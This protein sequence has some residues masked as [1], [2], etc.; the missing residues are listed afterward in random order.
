MRLGKQFEFGDK[1]AE[2]TNMVGYL[3]SQY[4]DPFYP[5]VKATD[6][7]FVTLKGGEKLVN[8]ASCDYLGFSKEE[9]LQDVAIEAIRTHGLNITGAQIF[10]GY[11]EIHRDLEQK[12]ARLYNKEGACLFASGML[13]N[14]GVLTSLVGPN[15]VIF[16]DIYNHASLIAGSKLS[17]AKNCLFPHNKLDR[18]DRE[19]AKISDGTKKLIAVDGVYSADG[20]AAP[21]TDLAAIAMKHDA[22]LVV[23]EAHALGVI[24]RNLG[25]A[26]DA[27]S[28]LD[29]VTVITGTMSKA[30]G[31]VGGFVAGPAE[32]IDFLK[33]Q[34]PFATSSRG[35]PYGLAA[36]SSAALDL[37]PSL[38][39]ERA[40]KTI[41]S[42]NYFAD[43]NRTNG[44]QVL[45]GPSA[46]VSIIFGEAPATI[47]MA[48]RLRTRGIL[49]S[50]MLHPSVPKRL[51]RLRF[52]VTCFH[53]DQDIEG[54]ADIIR[55]E[56]S[57]T[58]QLAANG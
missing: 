52:C 19:L 26:A 22:Y 31:S 33:H 35:T 1:I 37:L 40:E 57:S 20:D 46:I 4:Q 56:M 25:G 45:S 10:S 44:L 48:M 12:I 47:D 21:I 38:G 55:E 15:D 6:R 18:L 27:T 43:L 2:F 32:L 30:L 54:A 50:P 39:R 3:R 7:Q 53:E 11:S 13:A 14:I 36:A 41:R 49:A 8:F 58:P 29:K 24:G 23:D 51:T 9:Q 5:I 34:S 28:D 17:G 42:A 16:N